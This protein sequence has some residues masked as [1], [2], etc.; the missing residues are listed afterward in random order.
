MT[1]HCSPIPC[2]LVA[3]IAGFHPAGPGS[4]PGMGNILFLPAI[5]FMISL[6]VTCRQSRWDAKCS[7]YFLQTSTNKVEATYRENAHFL[8]RKLSQLHHRWSPFE[9]PEP[10]L[11]PPDAHRASGGLGPALPRSGMK[12]APMFGSPPNWSGMGS[13]ST[14]KLGLGRPK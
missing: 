13:G 2:G 6:Y 3:R 11:C 5:F 14:T 9:K 12:W 1:T 8:Q 4:I 10:I 7:D